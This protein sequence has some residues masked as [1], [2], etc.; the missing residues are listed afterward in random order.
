MD[1][2]QLL[3]KLCYY[4]SEE[5]LQ[6]TF[7]NLAFNNDRS[8]KIIG[9]GIDTMVFCI[10]TQLLTDYSNDVYKTLL[11]VLQYNKLEYILKFSRD[12]ERNKKCIIC[13]VVAVYHYGN[14]INT[15]K[16]CKEDLIKCTYKAI[17]YM[18]H[19]TRSF[20]IISN[21]NLSIFS[22]YSQL[23]TITNI[24]ILYNVLN[25]Y[26]MPQQSLFNTCYVCNA[27]KYE[28]L[29]E[30]SVCYECYNLI[31]ETYW[32]QC[33]P[34]IITTLYY[35]NLVSDVKRYIAYLIIFENNC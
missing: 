8:I 21:D 35:F 10:T 18:P 28:Y 23:Y 25:F 11:N 15:C 13:G 29:P 9:W 2:K 3:D 19:S 6:A 14:D 16:L 27:H 7:D 26:K 1:C 33:G 4:H 32:R 34:A 24:H 5:E 31:E 30:S 22:E 20:A 17:K 12:A